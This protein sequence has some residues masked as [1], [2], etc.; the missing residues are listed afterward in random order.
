MEFPS[1]PECPATAWSDDDWIT[2]RDGVRL[3]GK[4]KHQRLCEG[5]PRCKPAGTGRLSIQ[6]FAVAVVD[7]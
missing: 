7:R 3:D 6:S 1:A 4:R 2:V 5:T